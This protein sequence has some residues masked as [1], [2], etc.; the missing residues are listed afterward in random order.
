[1]DKQQKLQDEHK[2]LTEGLPTTLIFKE[3]D[4]PTPAFVLNRGEY[5]QKGEPVSRRVPGFLPKLPKDASNDRLGFANWLVASDNPLTARVAV[6]RMWQ[7]IFGTGIVATSDDFGLQGTPPSHPELLD[8][9]A[10]EYRESGWDTKAMLKRMVLSQAYQRSAR[11]SPE[12][13]EHDPK[14][15]LLARGPRYRLDA[16]MIRDQ[17]LFLGDLLVEKIGGPSVKPPQPAGLWEAVGYGGSNTVKFIADQG[18][19]KVHRRSLYTFWKRTAP[20][21]QMVIVDAPSRESCIIRRER[22]NTPLQA[23]LFMNEPQFVESARAFAQ[24]AMLANGDVDPR[25]NWMFEQATGRLPSSEE[26][27]V[28][29]RFHDAQLQVYENDVAA[30]RKLIEVGTTKPSTKLNVSELAA[31][32]MVGNLILN[33]DTVLNK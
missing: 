31:T 22:T 2:K 1:M 18:H 32:T 11:L 29:K 10:V 8:Y 14:N 33:M 28:L 3:L 30:A 5:D 25:L 19:E 23:L 4:K 16:E 12:L 6:N 9:L 13:L 24:R 17:A 21:P 7:T 15:L 26:M 27:D 20:P